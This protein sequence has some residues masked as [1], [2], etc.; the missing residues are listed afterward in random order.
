VTG[1]TDRSG[2]VLGDYVLE[3]LLGRGGMG[4][5]YLAR[6]TRRGR[7]VALKL[8]TSGLAHDPQFRER[9]LRESR[10]A[11]RINNPHVVPIHD[12]GEVAG[13]LFLDMRV[14]RGHNLSDIL[15]AGPI[16]ADRAV[17][18]IGQVASALDVAHAEGLVHRDVKP[19]NILIAAN[20][21]V[22]LAD[23][24]LA[25]G[26]TDTRITQTGAAIGSFSYMAPERFGP[27]DAISPSVDIYAL[28]CVLYECLS[29]QPPFGTG[30]IHRLIGAHISAPPP[31]LHNAFDPVIATALNKSPQ[32]RFATAGQLAHAAGDAASASGP[33]A[34][35]VPVAAPTTPLPAPPP[36]APAPTPTATARTRVATAPPMSPPPPPL[37]PPPPTPIPTGERR[38]PRRALIA[39]GIL[40]ALVIVTITAV[41]V[42]IAVRGPSNP[43]AGAGL[44]TTTAAAGSVAC[45]YPAAAHDGTRTPTPSATQPASGVTRLDMHTSRGTIGIDLDHSSAPCNAGAIAALARARYY[46]DMVCR[47]LSDYILVC[48]EPAGATETPDDIHQVSAGPGWTSPDE[49]PTDLPSAGSTDGFGRA[50]VSYPRGSVSVSVAD[51][52]LTGQSNPKGSATFFVAIRPVISAPI[53]THVGTVDPDGMAV[54]DAISTGGFTPARAGGYWGTPRTVPEILSIST[55]GT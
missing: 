5:V 1:P 42:A 33:G 8:L 53:Y 4:E 18:I 49:V 15:A 40:A 20:D 52:Q 36:M 32:H 55:M 17:R 45:S 6:D 10:I 24:G 19:D 37:F 21:F 44:S 39:G 29:G 11:A 13:Q 48:G 50:Q 22:Y 28:G 46:D 41:M 23:F 51:P 38:G 2:D 54:V 14:V 43:V 12:W 3:R 16:P 31:L 7:E 35:P 27:T 47:R 9:F 25:Q 26:I 34:A 30:D